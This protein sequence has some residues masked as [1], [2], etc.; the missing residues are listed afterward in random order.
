[1]VDSFLLENPEISV[2]LTLDDRVVNLVEEG[3]DVAIRIRALA[4][5][6]LTARRLATARMALCAAPAY[7]ARRAAPRHPRDL[8]RH[9]C[10]VYDYMARQ[11]V[12]FFTREGA[13]EDVR[14]GGRLHGNNGDV[15]VQAAVDGLG[16]VMTRTRR[17]AAARLSRFCRTGAR[18]SPGFTPSCRRAGSMR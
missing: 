14:V 6:S 5:S 17:S 8:A 2:E 9:D 11:G 18:W 16:V 1:M 10:L 3:F 13:A 7:L 12:W 15:L 4:D